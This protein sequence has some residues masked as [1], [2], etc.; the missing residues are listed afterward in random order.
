MLV[1][2]VAPM[3]RAVRDTHP[4]KAWWWLYKTDLLGPAIRLRV[5]PSRYAGRQVADAVRQ[6]LGALGHTCSMPCYEPELLLFGGTYGMRAA[7]DWFSAD[8]EFLVSWAATDVS[9]RGPLI[10]EALSLAL[11]MHMLRA[12][13]LDVFECWD[14][15]HA[16]AQKRVF[17]NPEDKRFRKYE[18]LAQRVI[19]AGPTRV[20][21]LYQAG[22]NRL[23]AD[24]VVA[25]SELGRRLRSLYATGCLECGLREFFVPLILFHWNRLMLSPYAHF[26]L[27]H[28]VAQE[29]WRV[30]RRDDRTIERA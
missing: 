5:L 12:A 9:G 17:G 25:L 16:V 22:Q 10:P 11:V 20:L 14:V 29:L 24:H 27:S 1:H 2:E 18:E 19:S 28:A 7:H 8:S 30:V 15:F 13:G 3:V 6:G 21:E 23:L 4:V 26:G